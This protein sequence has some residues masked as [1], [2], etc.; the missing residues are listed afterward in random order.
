MSFGEGDFIRID[1]TAR[2]AS[3][4][5]LVYTTI[6]KVAKDGNIYSKESKYVPQ[7]VVIGKGTVV[8]GVDKEL[9][10]MNVNDSKKIEVEPADGFGE[11]KEDLVSVMHLADFRKRDMDPQPGMQVDIDGVIAT[12]KSVNSGR[13]VVDANHPLAGEKLLYEVKVVEKIDGENKKAEALAELY[14]LK[15]DSIEHSGKTLKVTF[16]ESIEKN[17]DYLLNK[18]AFVQAIFAYMPDVEKVNASEEY[19]RKK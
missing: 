16:G 19:A 5:T 13:V 9:R 7:L 6:E 17:A 11:R 14:N 2:H 15:P 1:Y 3:D 10:S 18:S 12:V 8:K 4:N